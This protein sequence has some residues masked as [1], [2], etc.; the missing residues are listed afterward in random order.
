MK[1][2]FLT[3]GCM[4]KGHPNL[5]KDHWEHDYEF[6]PLHAACLRR[7]INLQA[8]VWDDTRFIIEEFD[9]C[10]I[11]T[12]WDYTDKAEAFLAALE[13]FASRRPLFNPLSIVRWNL[14]K[15]YLHQLAD[16]GVPTVPTLWRQ[17]ADVETI[18]RAFDELKVDEI[19]VKPV[20]GAS[21]WRQVRMKRGE[22]LPPSKE[23][24]PAD[25]MIQPFLDTVTTEG[26][27][28]FLFFD[29]EFSHCARK[30]P[31]VGDYRVQ[32]MFGGHEKVYHP[33]PGELAVA[34]RVLAAVDGP[35]LYARVDM[36]RLASG[37]LALMELELVEPYLYP[38]QGPNVGESFAVA[39]E[40]MLDH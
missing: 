13:R 24:P 20:V 4:L 36:L 7:G 40:R 33:N 18:E 38:E 8:V 32:T 9:A 35:L 2:A 39:L 5:R 26:E 12:T 16:K 14:N 22:N 30:I 3:A 21:A 25:T 19:V 11:G 15:T 37:E 1:I 29:R 23:L 31:Q 6:E 27:F 28:S 17:R 34:E 10:V